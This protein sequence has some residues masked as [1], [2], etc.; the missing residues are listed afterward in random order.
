MSAQ[1][2]DLNFGKSVAIVLI[3]LASKLLNIPKPAHQ[4]GGGFR[5]FWS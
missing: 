2:S 3:E 5:R 4:L 1:R